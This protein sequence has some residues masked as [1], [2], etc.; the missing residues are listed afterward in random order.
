MA[1]I[2]GRDDEILWQ[3][4]QKGERSAFEVIYQTNIQQLINYGYK[5]TSDRNVI[6]DCTQD[7]FVEL[8][9]NRERLSDVRSIRY[10]LLKSLRYKI[11]RH[12]RTHALSSF[13][14]AK[15]E[16]E[17]NSPEFQL[18]CDEHSEI[19]TRHLR[20]ALGQLPKRQ[21]EAIHLRYFLGMTNDEVA[22]IMGINYQSACKFLYTA[23]KTLRQTLHL[24]SLGP[25][26]LALTR[27]F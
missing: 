18:L 26:L 6:Q 9:E 24:K 8:W 12:L 21:Q 15:L 10:Y 7:L 17:D 27:F 11:V 2:Y 5:I 3:A 22:R 14:E 4:F 20:A 25:L 16:V 19:Q 13:E 23:L 1:S